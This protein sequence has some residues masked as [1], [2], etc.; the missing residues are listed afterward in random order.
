[1]D[2]GAWRAAVHGVTRVRQDLVTKVNSTWV[3]KY[4]FESLLS[5]LLRTHTHTQ[6]FLVAQMVK[7]L[8]AMKETQFQSLD[9]EDPWRKEWQPTPE[10]LSGEFNGQRNLVG[11]NPWSCKQ[12]D[13]TE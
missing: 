3:Q 8:P 2:R 10:F 7:N 9:G 6:A 5:I 12:L 11:Y 1:M 13:M 4:L